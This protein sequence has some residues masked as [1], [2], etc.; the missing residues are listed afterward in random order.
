MDRSSRRRIATDPGLS[1]ARLWLSLRPSMA[2]RKNVLGVR[3]PRCLLSQRSQGGEFCARHTMRRD[4]SFWRLHLPLYEYRCRGCGYSFEKIQRFS[5]EPETV[6]PK[7]SGELFRP[8]TAPA[9]QFKGSGW[10]I[11]DYA[12]KGKAGA[13][14]ES[15]ETAG[16]DSAA[17]DSAASGAETKPAESTA[18]KASEAAAPA[19]APSSGTS[20]APAAST[21]TSS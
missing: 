9:L 10:Y 13:T 8:M 16:A 2:E 6:C 18:P 11:N 21:S 15:G 4:D 14:A 3:S 5:A 17:P 7:C 12:S 1:H 20:A 19:P